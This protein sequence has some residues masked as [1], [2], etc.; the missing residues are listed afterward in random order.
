M[1]SHAERVRA[2]V[3]SGKIAP[4]EG[5]RILSAL[6][7]SALTEPPA[8][9][10]A[11]LLVDPFERF[12][13]GMGVGLGLVAA[14]ASLGATRLGIRF[15][16]FLDLHAVQGAPSIGSAALELAVAW[17][18]GA[19]VLWGGAQAVKRGQRF[20][21]FLAGVGIARMPLALAGL[22]LGGL[23]YGVPS[24]AHA[25]FSVRT[26]AILAI[27]LVAVAWHLTLLYRGF[28]H[29][30]GLS[31]PKLVATFVA[32]VVVA[33]IASKLVLYASAR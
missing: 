7:E 15:D 20:I 30:S 22:L 16:G 3:R 11:W 4:D 23:T 10:W 18:L 25:P 12:G 6:S 31:G 32:T 9:G 21:D 2:L 26:A 29:A 28:K 8:R 33:E 1:S 5:Q 19:A 27:A 13:G 17:P 24:E 14:L